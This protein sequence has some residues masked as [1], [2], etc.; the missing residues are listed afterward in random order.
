MLTNFLI[1][2][3]VKDYENTDDTKV[4]E[5]YGTLSSVVGIICNIILFAA[6]FIMGNI[7]NSIARKFYNESGLE[8]CALAYEVSPQTG[9][10]LMQCRHCLRYSFGVCSKSGVKPSWREPLYLVS[11]D[12]RRFRL[13]FDCRKCQMNI[14]QS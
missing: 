8:N 14:F 9:K 12:G 2:S 10:I 6:K 3:F 5:R 13:E 11:S 1:R 7:A 4:R